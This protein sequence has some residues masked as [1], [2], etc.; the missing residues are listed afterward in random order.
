MRTIKYIIKI[1][2]AGMDLPRHSQKDDSESL[3]RWI[4]QR[5]IDSLLRARE[6]I[7]AKGLESHYENHLRCPGSA[8]TAIVAGARS[9]FSLMMIDCG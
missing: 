1:G 7:R 3:N 6:L 9:H 4:Y 5:R 2:I 8:G